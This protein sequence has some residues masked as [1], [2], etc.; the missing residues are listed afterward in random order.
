MCFLHWFS[1]LEVSRC[2]C[3]QTCYEEQKCY[4]NF[5]VRSRRCFKCSASGY[6]SIELSLWEPWLLV[7]RCSLSLGN[8]EARELGNSEAYECCGGDER[9]A[10]WFYG[11]DLC[12]GEGGYV[13]SSETT[14]HCAHSR[15]NR[16]IPCVQATKGG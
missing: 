16:C 2:K 12:V 4:W 9:N 8:T 7:S 13:V 10:R 5:E 3:R 6:Q 15:D 1:N 11:S 14:D